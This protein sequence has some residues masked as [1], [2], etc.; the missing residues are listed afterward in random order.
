MRYRYTPSYIRSIKSIKDIK[1]LKS[2]HKAIKNFQETVEK[3]LPQAA[4]LGIKRLR[5]N[6]WEFRAGLKD[7][8]LVRWDKDLIE[9]G[10]VGTHDEIRDYLKH[11]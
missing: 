8:I 9:Y 11:L 3:S 6:I 1:R 5:D 10:I 2:I 4:G 7:R